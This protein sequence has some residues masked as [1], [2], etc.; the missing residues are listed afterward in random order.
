MGRGIRMTNAAMYLLAVFALATACAA[1]VRAEQPGY[2]LDIAI[3][4]PGARITGTAIIDTPKGAELSV[5]RGDLHILS[6]AT[7]SRLITP[8]AEETGPLTLRRRDRSLSA[9]RERLRIRKKA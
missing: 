3:D 9:L 5:Y 7:G 8:N 6:L 2:I 1:G 4:V